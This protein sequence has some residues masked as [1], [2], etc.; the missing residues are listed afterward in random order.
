MTDDLVS[1][2]SNLR[3]AALVLIEADDDYLWLIDL[4]HG[5]ADEIERLRDIIQNTT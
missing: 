4:L 2:P 1:S 3:K 5:A